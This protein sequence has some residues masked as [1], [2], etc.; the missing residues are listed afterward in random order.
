MSQKIFVFLLF[1][2]NCGITQSSNLGVENFSGFTLDGKLIQLSSLNIPRVALN[3]YSPT[4]MPCYKEIPTLNLIQKELEKSKLGKLYVVVDPNS[5]L[6][7]A[8][9]LSQEEKIQQ[10]QNFMK[11]EVQKRNI[12]VEVLI[13]NPP[14]QVTPGKGL[15][16]GTPETL[17]FKTNPFRLYYNFIGSI[18]EKDSEE[19]IQKDSR[20]KFFMKILG[21]I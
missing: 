5:I 4:C 19:E 16:T 10:A 14:F 21:G 11:E 8:E 6:E 17:L 9:N 18:C 12:Q 1:L 15:V 3:V 2:W 7:D 13:M 20:Y